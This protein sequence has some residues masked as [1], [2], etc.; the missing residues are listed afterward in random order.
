MNVYLLKV[1]LL[2]TRHKAWNLLLTRDILRVF[3]ANRPLKKP[4][5]QCLS[6]WG[7]SPRSVTLSPKP[8]SQVR[9]IT[10]NQNLKP[11]M[12]N[13]KSQ[14]LSPK[15][16][17]SQTPTLHR[18]IQRGTV[19]SWQIPQRKQAGKRP[20]PPLPARVRAFILGCGLRV[21]GCGFV[22]CG[23]MDSTTSGR[24]GLQT[25]SGRRG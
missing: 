19:S 7:L 22:G 20:T 15:S 16:R 1:W 6:L 4:V 23:L 2:E 21:V 10:S 24:A 5:Q 18:K 14:T 8:K 12:V 11:Q 9:N 17:K 3:T 25:G 13:P